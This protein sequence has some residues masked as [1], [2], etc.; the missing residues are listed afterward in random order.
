MGPRRG[1][2]LRCHVKGVEAS[3]T[4]SSRRRS[5]LLSPSVDWPRAWS[6][7]FKSN[8]ERSLSEYFILAEID[9][10]TEKRK[11]VTIKVR[12]HENGMSTF[13]TFFSARVRIL[14]DFTFD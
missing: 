14:S 11:I 8:A 9:D 6:I 5:S 13:A 1:S 2:C 7:S 12:C 4:D 10:L 3:R